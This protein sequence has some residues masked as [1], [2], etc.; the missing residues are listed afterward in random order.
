M[1][2]R[3][4]VTPE[5]VASEPFTEFAHLVGQCFETEKALLAEVDGLS[6]KDRRAFAKACA[7][8]DP[9]APVITKKGKA[10]PDPDLR[11]QE[12]VPLPEGFFDLDEE[13]RPATLN[14]EAERHLAEEIHPYV[15][16]AWIDH[17]KAKV[18]VEI[19][20]TRQFYIY[21]PPRPVEEIAT[22]IKDLESQIDG[23]MKG[24]EL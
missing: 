5:A 4:K 8:A 3:W 19:P 2:R 10:E 23:W 15:P 22:E 24:L 18:G 16:D 6:A 13:S 14:R 9:D 20:F 17:A 12:N 1:R 11:D 21:E 7:I